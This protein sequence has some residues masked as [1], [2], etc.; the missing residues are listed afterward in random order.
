MDKNA[1]EREVLGLLPPDDRR[2]G[3]LVSQALVR[4]ADGRMALENLRDLS[5]PA[6]PPVR[7]RRANPII[8]PVTREVIGYEMVRV[9][10]AASA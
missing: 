9:P 7:F 5:P 6:R 8:D 10:L 2:D 1:V 3:R 4:F